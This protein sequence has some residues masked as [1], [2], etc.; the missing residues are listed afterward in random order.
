MQSQGTVGP[1]VRRPPGYDPAFLGPPEQFLHIPLAPETVYDATGAPS[2]M[3]GTQHPPAQARTFQ[4]APARGV[5]MP[6][7]RYFPASLSHRGDHELRQV[8]ASQRL[9]HP[10]LQCLALE[11]AAGRTP[12]QPA[13]FLLGLAQRHRDPPLLSAQ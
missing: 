10:V 1:L 8:L 13:E 7:E 5:H 2:M 6:M 3:I 9:L 11:A 12:L 4:Q